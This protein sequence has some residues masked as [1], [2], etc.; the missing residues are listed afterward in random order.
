MLRQ[1]LPIAI[2]V[3]LGSVAAAQPLALEGG[4]GR[5][6]IDPA[7]PGLTELTLRRPD[8]SLE[9]HSILSPGGYPWQRG[10]YDWGTGA[11]TYC[12]DED[13]RRL[14]SRRSS[15]TAEL[16]PNGVIL[17]DVVL[18]TEDGEVAAR[19]DWEL[20][21]A[22]D[23]LVWRVERRWERPLAIAV[24]AGPALFFSN[25]PVQPNPA[26]A[27]PNGVATTLWLNPSELRGR[28]LP[29][30]RPEQWGYHYKIAWENEVVMKEPGGWAVA[31]TFPTWPAE[32]DPR[33][34]VEGG[35]LYRRGHFGWVS[36]MGVTA[37]AELTRAVAPGDTET[38]V[39]RISPIAADS[40]GHQLHVESKEG[41]AT[42]ER[43]AGFYGGLLNGGCVNDPLHYNFG[44][45]T[46]GWYY[47]GASW[48][49]GMPLLVGAPAPDPLASQPHDAVTAFRDNLAM[50]AG[51]EF[52]PGLTR[53]GYNY[54]GSYTDDNLNQIIGGRAY[55]LYS[56]DAA[57]VRQHV[58]Y[59][60]RAVEWYL[61]RR[62]ETGLVSLSPAAHWYYDAMHAEG[63]TTYHNSFLYRALRD[64]AELERAAGDENRAAEWDAQADALKAAI[65][66][67]L[68]W[69]EAP[70]GPRYADWI[71]TDGTRIAYAADLCQ[72]PPVAFGIA[73]PE[74]GRALLDTLDRRIEELDG[75]AGYAS[76]SA[77]WPVP[78]SV[79][80]H[81][82]NQG[83]GNYMNGGSFLSMTYWEI[84]ARCA[85]G[86]AEGAWRRLSRFAEGTLLTGEHGFVGNNWVMQDGRIGHGAGDEPYLSDAIAVP[87]ALVRGV[88]GV[89]H[90]NDGLRVEPLLPE[91]LGSVSAEVVHLGIR[92]RV[93]ID[94]DRVEVE[95]LGRA[96]TPPEEITW[97]LDRGLPPAA[98]LTIQRTF[99][100]GREWTTA[101][102]AR[103]RSGTG[104]VLEYVP[105]SDLVGLWALDATGDAVVD[106]SEYRAHGEC[107]G[108]VARGAV[109]R[110]GQAGAIEV[111]G[112]AH[113]VVGD[114]EPYR[115]GPQESFTVQAWFRTDS[116][117]NQVIIARPGAFSLGVK[118]GH[119]AAWIMEASG[120][121]VEAV[122]PSMVADGGWH[123]GAAVYDREAQLLR[124]FVDGRPDGEPRDI[125]AIG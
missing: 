96:Y 93:T 36:E 37:S 65:N 33:V 92:K 67:V 90:G 26:T 19:E 114:T 87:A 122:G 55:Y 60:R 32:S 52:E 81:P 23:A 70:G 20:T 25:R 27:L 1:S 50:I 111:S 79:N 101:G 62:N 113:V 9:P 10:M 34:S 59:Y 73:S 4:F 98:G 115:F 22:D 5:A 46:E 116:L 76:L 85:A 24:S 21:P 118:E 29:E 6:M 91:G 71:T 11:Y 12:V 40:T 110:N 119:P 74:R 49:K 77:Y 112:G 108:Q 100:T 78:S 15:A 80:T 61:A 120:A 64:L 44:N 105:T 75:Y 42:F 3:G 88:L 97:S 38:M 84:M 45:E 95:D 56:G 14:E 68:W 48:M 41:S 35:H 104:V 16:T 66:E 107:V 17:R 54:S 57:F 124:L 53:F 39:L 72:F 8:G 117:G 30:Y 69:D 18:V 103:V 83:Y 51:T 109:D 31:K 2:L 106:G 13:G 125:G 121:Y 94:G 63:A 89:Q 7:R 99:D 102:Q 58:P 28:H 82:I 86:D 43:L 47:G 123:H